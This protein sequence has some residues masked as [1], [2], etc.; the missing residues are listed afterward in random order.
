M[1]AGLLDRRVTVQRRTLT[2]NEYGEQ[3]E[4]WTEY[5]TVYASRNDFLVASTGKESFSALQTSAQETTRFRMR[6][7]SDLL[8]TDRL[9]SDGRT[10]DIKQIS[11]MGRRDGLEIIGVARLD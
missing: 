5:A 3:V 4:T 10:Y 9:V 11:E 2:R 7:R 1:L 8:T 6:Y